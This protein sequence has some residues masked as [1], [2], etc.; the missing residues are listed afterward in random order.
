VAVVDM[1]RGVED[2]ATT[3]E[4]PVAG[5]AVDVT[6]AGGPPCRVEDLAEE[7]VKK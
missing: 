1:D 4:G 6:D 5:M 2:L 3:L 7:G